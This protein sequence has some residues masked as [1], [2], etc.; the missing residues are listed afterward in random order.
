[1]QRPADVPPRSPILADDGFDDWEEESLLLANPE[2]RHTASSDG[3]GLHRS[4]LRA[5]ECGAHTYGFC[6][7]QG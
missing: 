1:M 5:C 3:P 7:S 6:S 4:A 2:L